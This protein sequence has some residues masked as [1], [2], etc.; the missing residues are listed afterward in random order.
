MTTRN[1][2]KMTMSYRAILGK[3][4]SLLEKRKRR[5]NAG[6]ISSRTV[7]IIKRRFHGVVLTRIRRRKDGEAKRGG[8]PVEQADDS[9][10]D[11]VHELEDVT[12]PNGQ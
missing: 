9:D 2:G 12:A 3:K 10:A 8:G 1:K 7:A 4:P 11:G 5:M 6:G